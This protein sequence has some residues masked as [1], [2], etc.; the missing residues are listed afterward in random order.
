MRYITSPAN[1][2]YKQ[3]KKLLQHSN[4]EKS[5]LFIAEGERIVKD[6][7]HSAC[8]RYIL[9]NE[10]YKGNFETDLPFYRLPDKLFSGISDTRTTQG[11]IAVCTAGKVALNDL[12]DGLILICDGI[13]DPGNLGTMIRTAECAGAGGVLLVNDCAD[14]Y[15]PK[16]VRSTMGSIFRI[17]V[18]KCSVAELGGLRGYDIAAAVPEGADN[19]YNTRFKRKTAVLIGNEAHGISKEALFFANKRVT[20]PMAK[21]AESLNAAVAAGIIM[22]EAYRQ[23]SAGGNI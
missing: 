3:T 5:G 13:S 10:S 8:A 20:I 17:P 23:N 15:S 22:Y 18:C 14:V 9:I 7:L 12:E 2:I 16:T 11:I 4:R 19:L 1:T 21:G 6:A